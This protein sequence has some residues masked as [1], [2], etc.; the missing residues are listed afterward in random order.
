MHTTE[1]TAIQAAYLYISFIYFFRVS[2]FAFVTRTQLNTGIPLASIDRGRSLRPFLIAFESAPNVISI[3]V[4]VRKFGTKPF[5]GDALHRVSVSINAKDPVHAS[6]NV[7]SSL[8]D[9]EMLCLKVLRTTY[10]GDYR[11]RFRS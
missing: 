9:K 5:D 10:S 3:S 4:N 6:H 7:I 1:S 2:E 11:N 8:T